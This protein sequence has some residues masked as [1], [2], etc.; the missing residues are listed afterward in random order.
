MVPKAN[1]SSGPEEVCGYCGQSGQVTA[2]ATRS[3]AD[4]PEED[5]EASVCASCNTKGLDELRETF[6][7]QRPISEPWRLVPK[8][9]RAG[10]FTKR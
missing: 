10:G 3:G 6:V 1:R 8:A 2:V 9:P 7:S 4:N 5:G